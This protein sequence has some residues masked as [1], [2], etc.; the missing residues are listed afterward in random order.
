MGK[1]QRYGGREIKRWKSSHAT[2]GWRKKRE[3]E[4][5]DIDTIV[6]SFVL[7]LLFLLLINVFPLVAIA[8]TLR[9]IIPS[10]S[11]AL[12]YQLNVL[13]WHKSQLLSFSSQFKCSLVYKWH[14]TLLLKCG[15]NLHFDYLHFEGFLMLLSCMSFKLLFT[16]HVRGNTS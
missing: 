7:S 12:H 1:K 3:S 9:I 14:H 4:R 2:V 16:S 8:I 13:Y 10:L 11:L 15:Y 5:R 6:L